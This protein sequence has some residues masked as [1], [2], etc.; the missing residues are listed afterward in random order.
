MQWVVTL[1]ASYGALGDE[2]GRAVAGRLQLPF[3][4]RAVP[5]ATSAQQL[6][7]PEEVAESLEEHPPSG[8]QQ[9]AAVFASKGVPV[10]PVLRPADMVLTPA[11]F[12]SVTEAQLQHA[13]D[14]TGAVV[15]G[16]AAM[17]VLG[18]RPD[19]LCVRLDGPVEA[20][21]AQVM[22]QGADEATARQRQREVDG[23]R[24][25]YAQAFS[26]SVRTILACIT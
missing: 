11:Q 6:G 22:A 17:V 8:R 10:G 25:A 1:S 16:R 24:E 9:T 19:V 7:L 20:R 5:T 18:G 23:A 14:R 3:I 21:I 4:E 26:T 13:A 12:R 2:V 15:V